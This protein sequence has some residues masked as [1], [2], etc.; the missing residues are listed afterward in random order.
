[1][2][3]AQLVSGG[4]N[5]YGVPLG[6]LM[7]ESRFP[8]LP[9]DNGNAAT[10]PFPV[11]Y[12]VVPGAAP[13]R[14]VRSLADR[15]LLQPFVDAALE[16]ERAGVGAITTSCGFLVLYQGQIQDALQIPFL[17]SS[18]LQVPWVASTLPPG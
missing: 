2:D 12:R 9:G 1:M 18:L 11:L 5:V 15:S 17:S 4:R 7:T 3:G 10:W 6:M 13:G 16:L 8:R 14:V